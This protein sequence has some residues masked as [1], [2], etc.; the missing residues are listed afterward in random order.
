MIVEAEPL[1][2]Q[3]KTASL[4]ASAL[5]GPIVTLLRSPLW[6]RFAKVNSQSS[7]ASTADSKSLHNPRPPF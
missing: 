7:R 1:L 3:R 5:A 6:V 4:A 2:G